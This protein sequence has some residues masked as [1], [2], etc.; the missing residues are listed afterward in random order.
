MHLYNL[1]LS[2]PSAISVSLRHD[3]SPPGLL[4]PPGALV[5]QGTRRRWCMAARSHRP[6]AQP[7]AASGPAPAPPR[8]HFP[9]YTLFHA[10][11]C[12]IYGNFSAPKVHEIVA[13]R[14]KV[15]ELLRP[16]DAGKVQ[17]IHSTEV[18]GIIRSLAPFRCVRPA[19]APGA[20]AAACGLPV[21]CLQGPSSGA[22][23]SRG[24]A[25]TP[26]RHARQPP[27]QQGRTCR[28]RGPA[29]LLA[30][31][32]VPGRAAGL[33]HLRVG[34]W[35]HRDPAVQQ[36][37]ELLHPHPHRDVWQVGVQVRGPAWVGR[38]RCWCCGTVH[39]QVGL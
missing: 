35:A 37:K 12:A 36:G 25:S 1:T 19:A 21:P 22:S 6:A 7:R 9:P 17:V 4:P 11:Q 30:W 24:C 3:C 18:F 31:L 39:G 26:K 23:S 33:R 5:G 34:L 29:R 10:P 14:G 16:D 8:R 2:R 20:C 28:P 15:L 32:Q 27:Q 13:A 38:A